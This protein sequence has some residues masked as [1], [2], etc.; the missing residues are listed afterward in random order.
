MYLLVAHKRIQSLLQGYELSLEDV[1]SMQM[2]CAY[3]VR[4]SRAFPGCSYKYSYT[5][6]TVSLGYSAF[7]P[8]FTEDEWEGFE[9][10]LDLYFWY[11]SGFGSPVARALGSGYVLEL[12]SRLTSTPISLK[13]P[14]TSTFSVNTTLDGNPTTFPLDQPL[15][16]D[17]THEVVIVNILTALNLTSLSG[18][19]E[20]GPP[21]PKKMKRGR[22]WRASRVAP[23]A[24]NMQLQCEW[25][26]A[27]V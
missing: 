8:L 12:L 20:D 23:F 7:C 18:L 2:M 15:Y 1:Y 27:F 22:K 14:L 25:S 11:D 26:I 16:V 10:A 17:A 4:L 3:E 24:S 21:S 19:E 9:Y 5:F 13:P 6:Q